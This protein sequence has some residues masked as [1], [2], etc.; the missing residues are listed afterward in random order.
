MKKRGDNFIERE[1]KWKDI[2]RNT[3]NAKLNVDLFEIEYLLVHGTINIL[4]GNVLFCA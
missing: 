3:Q 2:Q 1:G 4:G